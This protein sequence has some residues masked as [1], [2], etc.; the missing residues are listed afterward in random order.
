MSSSKMKRF[1][2][3]MG[4]LEKAVVAIMYQ[5]QKGFVVQRQNV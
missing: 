1:E 4:A 5:K 2:H 3:Q